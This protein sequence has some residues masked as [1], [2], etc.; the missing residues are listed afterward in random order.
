MSIKVWDIVQPKDD[1][2]RNYAK[3]EYDRI[4]W[5][6]LWDYAKSIEV[7]SLFIC[8]YCGKP[9]KNWQWTCKKCDELECI[10]VDEAQQDYY[11]R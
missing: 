4:K 1:W 11:E 5:H 10:A 3:M 7:D 9:N 8:M 2:E 6:N